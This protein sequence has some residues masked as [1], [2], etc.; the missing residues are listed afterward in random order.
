M[1]KKPDEEY[2][3]EETAQRATAALRKALNTP[4]TPH[5]PLGKRKPRDKPKKADD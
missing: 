1:A 2:T 5:K 4:P 3:P